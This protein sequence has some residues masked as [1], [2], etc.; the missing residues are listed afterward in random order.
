MSTEEEAASGAPGLACPVAECTAHFRL[1]R[2]VSGVHCRVMPSF[3][4]GCNPVQ[5]GK[6]STVENLCHDSC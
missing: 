3:I 1:V 6:S 4:G 2:A 5:A